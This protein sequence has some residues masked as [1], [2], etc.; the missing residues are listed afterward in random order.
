M[1]EAKAAAVILAAGKG[2]RMKSA[3]PKVLHPIAGRPMIGHVLASLEPLGCARTAVVVAPGMAAVA[4]AVAPHPVAVQAQPLGTGHAVLA[5]RAALGAE[6]D[7]LLILYGDT[8]LISTATLQRLLERRR[9]ADRPAVVVLGMRPADPA[10]YGRLVLDGDGRLEA[11]V[12]FRDADAGQ[13]AI[14]LCHSGVMAVDGRLIW[15]LLAYVGN[16][17]A[18]GEYY[19]T[20]IVR[21]ARSKGRACTAI[22][23]PADELVGVNSRAELAL[24]EAVMQE[25][26]RARAMAEG[27]TLIDPKSVWFSVDTKLGRDVVVGPNVF[28]GL[29]VEIAD[30]VEIRG[31]CHFEGARVERGAE[32]GP[33]ARLRRGSVIGASARIGNFVETK[34]TR[35]GAGA[36]AN[37]LSYLGDTTVGEKANIGAGTITCNFDGFAKYK[38]AIGA[39]A[40]I[41]SNSA[42]CAPV[43]IGEGAFIA[44]GSVIT[45]DVPADALAVARAQQAVKPGWASLFRQMMKLKLTN[46]S[47]RS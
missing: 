11:I 12:E 26:L 25:R 37:H 39:G 33:F 21:L 36:K 47:G 43:T 46:G 1:A 22:E 27:A 44:A 13:R 34:N 20:D 41:G 42:L 31:F 17:N 38:T 30:E 14:A 7:D 32:I 6:N 5:A 16:A 8:P 3:L 35:L 4:Q 40:F 19:L 28:F 24:A 10:E 15:D 18:K 23:A 45:R 29:G 2:T 9:A